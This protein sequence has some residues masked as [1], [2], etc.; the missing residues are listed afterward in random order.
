MNLKKLTFN[1]LKKVF[2]ESIV[3]GVC[4]MITIFLSTY[5]VFN[6]VTPP[7]Y[8]SSFQVLFNSTNSQK[9]TQQL[10]SYKTNIQLMGTVSSIIKSSKVMEEVKKVVAIDDSAKAASKKI[11]VK[12]DTNSLVLIVEFSSDNSKEVELVSNQLLEVIQ[13]EIP[14]T[15]GNS[16]I[17]VLERPNI[18]RKVSLLPNYVLSLL[19]GIFIFSTFVIVKSMI[20]T[21]IRTPDQI[22]ELGIVFLGDIPKVKKRGK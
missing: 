8:T 12:S 15:F 21:R 11:S 3:L 4:I 14:E 1:N 2:K 5:L 18:P 10:D 20:D 9:E 13:S 16:T 6:V 19:I 22:K 7:T 17:T